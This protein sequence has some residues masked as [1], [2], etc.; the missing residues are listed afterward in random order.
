MGERTSANTAPYL[1]ILS[2]TLSV[3]P[4]ISG[5]YSFNK[6]SS[7]LS[8]ERRESAYGVLLVGWDSSC[9]NTDSSVCGESQLQVPMVLSNGNGLCVSLSGVGSLDSWCLRLTGDRKLPLGGVPILL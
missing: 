1:T 4:L 5:L 6:P 8:E 2:I 7:L 3:V 9:K